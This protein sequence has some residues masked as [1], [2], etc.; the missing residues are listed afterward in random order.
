MAEVE[1]KEDRDLPLLLAALHER[2]VEAQAAHWPDPSHDWSAHDVVV[3]R[4]TWDYSFHLNDYLAWTEKVG[5]VSRLCNPAEVVRWNSDKHY[6]Q[7]LAALGVPTVPTE[8]RSP[9]DGAELPAFARDGHFVVKPSVS[10]GAR[11]TARYR[12]DQTD[13]AQAHINSL[14]ESG[15]TAMLQPYLTRIAEGERAL[16]HVNGEFSHALRKGPVLTDTG[17]VDNNRVAHPDL[18][19]HEPNAAELAVARAALDA[20]PDFAGPATRELLY[21]RVDLALDDTGQ[22]VLMELELI[23]P[24]LFLHRSPDGLAR[25]VHAVA[26]L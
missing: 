10:A 15:A 11:D 2:G 12:P 14:H 18:V 3:I 16:V 17:I 25:F 19:A 21:A 7:D 8:F 1:L 5:A 23:E 6:L 4:S 9:G 24:N 20:V 13:L 22:P 26:A